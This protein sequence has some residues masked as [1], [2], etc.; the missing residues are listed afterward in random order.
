ME[1]IIKNNMK[2]SRHS[3]VSSYSSMMKRGK[4][5]CVSPTTTSGSSVGGGPSASDEDEYIRFLETEVFKTELE[6][7]KKE[8]AE[9]AHK[10]KLRERLELREAK[11]REA[12]LREEEDRKKADL[13]RALERQERRIR[14]NEK[15]LVTLAN[16][17]KTTQT[18]AEEQE[19]LLRQQ[20]DR[21]MEGV[22]ER[23][24]SVESRSGASSM[25]HGDGEGAG[26]VT[27]EQGVQASPGEPEVAKPGLGEDKAKSMID[28]A[29]K[30][31][32]D[33]MQRRSEKQIKALNRRWEERL[34]MMEERL[35]G[36]YQERLRVLESKVATKLEKIITKV[37]KQAG[38]ASGVGKKAAKAADRKKADAAAART[39][40][41]AGGAASG[42]AKRTT[43]AKHELATSLKALTRNVLEEMLATEAVEGI[44]SK[45]NR[46][47]ASAPVS[48]PSALREMPTQ[49]KAATKGAAP[50]R[51]STAANARP[52]GAA[53]PAKKAAAAKRSGS[54]GQERAK[55]D[56]E[57]RQERLKALYHEWTNLELE[58]SSVLLAHDTVGEA[59]A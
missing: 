13:D 37:A 29:V 5:G 32:E 36:E 22:E 51:S 45:E 48:E 44:P 18:F 23:L 25:S 41:R 4:G 9:H 40:D 42:G 52:S 56:Y 53:R 15:K 19:G 24:R 55:E 26:E 7:K 11:E 31:A 2:D 43:L 8:E 28:D 34:R 1:S 47:Q 35:G 54:T 14:E 16:L 10:A 21:S 57:K 58:S 12:E 39:E 17:V 20:L 27:V 59:P 38:G 46:V 6:R 50:L 49:A 33:R 3:D 30:A